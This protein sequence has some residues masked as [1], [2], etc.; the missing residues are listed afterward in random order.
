MVRWLLPFLFAGTALYVGSYNQT[1]TDRVLLFPFVEAIFPSTTND[2]RAQ[3]ERSVQL[4]WGVAGLTLVLAV[5]DTIRIRARR[6]QLEAADAADRAA[7]LP[8]RP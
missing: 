3:G 7:G 6:R 5:V 4:L 8:P 2:P 1:H